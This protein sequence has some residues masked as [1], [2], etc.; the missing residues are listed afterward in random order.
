[1]QTHAIAV[2]LPPHAIRGG[3]L[4]EQYIVWRGEHRSRVVAGN[5]LAGERLIREIL[6]IGRERCDGHESQTGYF[7]AGTS[8][9]TSPLC[10][11]TPKLCSRSSRRGSHGSSQTAIRSSSPMI[12]AFSVVDESNESVDSV[13]RTT[14]RGRSP[15]ARHAA[16]V[17]RT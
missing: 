5:D 1:M 3:K 11:T 17:N 16:S 7:S 13:F 6:P 8:S 14:A 9:S 12:F 4:L 10:S 2:I 15:A